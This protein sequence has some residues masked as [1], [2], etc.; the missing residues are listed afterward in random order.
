MASGNQGQG[1][2]QVRRGEA[3]DRPNGGPGT[4]A[5]QGGL[6]ETVQGFA[7]SAQQGMEQV[8]DRV[9]EGYDMTRDEMTR[10]YRRAEGLVARNPTPSVLIGFGLGFGVGLAIA[11]MLTSHEESWADRYLPDSMRDLTGRLRR[12]RVPD[13]VRDLPDA[14]QSSFHSLADSIRDLPSA[15][16]RHMPGR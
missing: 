8:S 4:A 5:G 9:R 16:A 2:G 11:A 14:L 6:R 13:P 10:R 12:A 1:Q 7:Q 3:R 15:I